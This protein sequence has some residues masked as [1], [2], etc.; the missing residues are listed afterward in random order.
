MCI[1]VSSAPRY[2][3][4]TEI[5]VHQSCASFYLLHA[6]SGKESTLGKLTIHYEDGDRQV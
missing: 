4:R 5:P 2:S 1:G 6:C 3:A